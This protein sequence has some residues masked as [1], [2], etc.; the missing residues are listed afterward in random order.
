MAYTET[1]VIDQ[2][3]VSENGNIIYREVTKVLRDDLQIAQ[4]YH[5]VSLYPGHDLTGQ[6]ERV[7]AIANAVWTQEVLDAFK[8][9]VDNIENK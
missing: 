4:T 9:S 8:A 1:K 3:T 6:P 2:I 5:R 7:V